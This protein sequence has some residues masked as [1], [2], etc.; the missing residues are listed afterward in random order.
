MADTWCTADS[1]TAG[2][3]HPAARNT[4]PTADPSISGLVATILTSFP[5][6]IFSPRKADSVMT[7]SALKIGTT[8]AASMA[9][10]PMS[11][12]GTSDAASGIPMTARLLRYMPCI[13]TP[14]F[15]WSFSVG[16]TSARD[17][18]YITSTAPTANSSS[19]GCTAC[20]SDDVYRFQNSI[21]GM[22]NRNAS[23]FS[24][25]TSSAL[26]APRHLAPY[27]SAI[28]RNSGAMALKQTCRLLS[29]LFTLS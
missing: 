17:M 21:T 8:T 16:S 9:T 6:G 13:F 22:K 27:P 29:I 20:S 15:S 7:A 18:P 14:C 25:G 5:A 26:M 10:G 1:S 4:T 2:S 12:P 11:A 28:T 19:F 24:F 3:F 23:L